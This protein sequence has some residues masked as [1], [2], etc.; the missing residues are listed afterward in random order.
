M[1]ACKKINEYL[2]NQLELI[3]QAATPIE[4]F[5]FPA[6]R[7]A[8]IERFLYR[9][10]ELN[11]AWE[12]IV[13]KSPDRWNDVV[14]TII[15]VATYLHPQANKQLLIELAD[16]NR[17]IQEIA[18]LSDQLSKSL[19][20]L[21]YKTKRLKISLP[22]VFSHP[23]DL[24]LAIAKQSGENDY[25]WWLVSKLRRSQL[26]GGFD[27]ERFPDMA[28]MLSEL[29]VQAGSHQLAFESSIKIAATSSQKADN[30][31]SF[32]RALMAGFEDLKKPYHDP[33]EN[34]TIP[35][36]FPSDFALTQQSIAD[37][38]TC[39]L[40]LEPGSITTA[41]IKGWKQGKDFSENHLINPNRQH[42]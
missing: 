10:S 30:P 28:R 26:G 25:Y 5:F 29:S 23:F 42:K 9:R 18:N 19:Q 17:T 39:A 3:N 22:N 11:N 27:L 14:Q 13:S 35:N 40:D 15:T 32:Y 16:A 2:E 34:V 1:N 8:V 38:I 21:S 24:V 20:G 31:A 37:I 6:E 33:F 4:K 12:D 7:V 41:N 36:P